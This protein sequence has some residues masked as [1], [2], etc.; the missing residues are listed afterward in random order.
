ME[1]NKKSIMRP[2]KKNK[3][4]KNI[5]SAKWMNSIDTVELQLSKSRLTEFRFN[6]V[7]KRKEKNPF[8]TFW[9]K[10]HLNQNFMIFLSFTMIVSY[11]RLNSIRS[12]FIENLS[13][14]WLMYIAQRTKQ[15]DLYRVTDRIPRLCRAVSY[16]KL[17]GKN[18]CVRRDLLSFP[19][20]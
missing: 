7:K 17:I 15:A 9:Q 12:V 10:C 5:N 6:W 2:P 13:F 3:I 1:K 16:R 11:W 8:L 18:V 4:Q 14:Y 20:S 19:E